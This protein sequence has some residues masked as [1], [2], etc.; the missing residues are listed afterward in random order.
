MMIA[1]FI[2]V[3]VYIAVPWLAEKG[4]DGVLVALRLGEYQ[5]LLPLFC[6]LVCWRI[7]RGPE[8]QHGVVEPLVDAYLQ[9]ATQTRL[10]IAGAPC[11]LALIL[12][13]YVVP[14]APWAPWG[15]FEAAV[16]TLPAATRDGVF[17]LRRDLVSAE[18][19]AVLRCASEEGDDGWQYHVDDGPRIGTLI[20]RITRD[21]RGAATRPLV[22]AL[23][24]ALHHQLPRGVTELSVQR[25]RN[26]APLVI[27]RTRVMQ[28]HPQNDTEALA[29]A[30]GVAP[31][32]FPY[33]DSAKGVGLR[34]GA[35]EF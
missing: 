23:V 12:F 25:R 18:T 15:S 4:P 35:Q 3:G 2:V 30:A 28:T 11:L 5:H 6:T 29:A 17:D 31:G 22:S 34:C 13:V 19:D 33:D 1:A 10:V 16:G 24:L 9:P 7:L 26:R 20:V 32:V 8:G 14:R 27:D 21:T